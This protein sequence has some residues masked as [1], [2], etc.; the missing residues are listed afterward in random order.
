V[1]KPILI[2]ALGTSLT[3]RGAWLEQLPPL[4]EPVIGQAVQVANFGV[5]GATS[6]YGVTVA[7]AVADARPDVATIEF[8]I[9]D[10]VIYRCMS[11]AE[12]AANVRKIIRQLR[13]ASNATR[14][15]LMTMNPAFG[16]RGLLRP[17]LERYY[18]QYPYLADCEQTGLIDIRAAWMALPRSVLDRTL[19]DGLHPIREAVSEHVLPCVAGRFAV[20]LRGVI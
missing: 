11:L 16:V 6:R 20:D 2:A 18:D 8:A 19:P 14:I 13:M 1:T 4:L 17:R 3:A 10:A 9:N 5:A 12:S 7:A 15:Y